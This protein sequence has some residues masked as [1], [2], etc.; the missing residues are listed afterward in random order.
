L[1][2]LP[3]RT[4]L[5]GV[6]ALL[7]VLPGL[8][9]RY[10]F[11][12]EVGL[13]G[14]RVAPVKPSLTAAGWWEGKLQ[15]QT[16]DWIDDRIGFRGYAVRTDN[17]IGVSLFG[18]AFTRAADPVVL[19]RR[20]MV[21]A[22]ADLVAYDG[23]DGFRDRTLRK[24]VR[25]L[26]RLQDALA[27][28]GIAFLF[29]ISPSKA[30]LY[31][32]YIPPGFVRPDGRR[33]ATA[34]ERMIRMLHGE[35]V[36][37]IDSHLILNE[38]K[39]R[40]PHALFPPGGVHWNRLAAGMV[41]RRAWQALGEQLGR[42]LVDLRWRDIRE[43]DAPDPADQE[44]DGANLLNAWRVGHADWKFPRP[45]FFTG[46]T[47]AFRPRLVVVGD[48]FWLT[49]DAFI[50]ERQMASRNDFFYYFNERAQSRGL[51]QAGLDDP[52]G[53]RGGMSWEYVFTADAIIVET[54]EAGIGV[55]GW[56]FVQAALKE[57][58][59]APGEPGAGR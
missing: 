47:D 51:H 24:Q 39:A 50:A 56:G 7:L 52:M 30:A 6:F 21:Y 45:V 3:P 44:T 54:N 48:S 19:G 43:D 23:L 41:L 1:R 17:Q 28:R 8:Q 29:L 57:L 33:P 42:P 5:I 35:G 2:H 20:M 9:M 36:H 22:D 58:R 31:P 27:R 32:E 53:L 16:E 37:V 14:V 46:D 34:Y 15:S 25:D 40:S 55:A 26:R 18:E 10:A 13:S 59:R 4:L 38:E 12:P 11:A 49:M